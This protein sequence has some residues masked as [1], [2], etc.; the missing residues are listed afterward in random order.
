M[1]F[2]SSSCISFKVRLISG[3]KLRLYKLLASRYK[4]PHLSAR[5]R[6]CVEYLFSLTSCEKL[7]ESLI[8]WDHKLCRQPNI[9]QDCT[10][11]NEFSTILLALHSFG[12]LG[13]CE[14][15]KSGLKTFELSVTILKIC[16][17]DA[18]SFNIYSES[19]I[20]YLTFIAKKIAA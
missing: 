2:K 14:K 5:F 3:E 18:K 12:F 15:W 6:F 13:C 8:N 17:N 1:Q 16:V 11:R 4:Q 19:S 7:S 9:W 20:K 10:A